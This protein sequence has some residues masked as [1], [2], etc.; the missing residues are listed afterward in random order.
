MPSPTFH[1]LSASKQKQIV[2][3]A[4]IEFSLLPYDKVS[5]FQIA[6]KSEVSRGTFYEYFENKLDIY[7]Y[8]LE[9]FFAGFL[10]S[11]NL[12]EDRLNIF[13]VAEALYDYIV[14]NQPQLERNFIR[15]ILK[16]TDSLTQKM[17][18]NNLKEKIHNKTVI[19]MIDDTE[20]HFDEYDTKMVVTM[21]LSTVAVVINSYFDEVNQVDIKQ[22]FKRSLAIIKYGVKHSS[23]D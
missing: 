16:N 6:K 3:T 15:M 18:E 13:D 5:I 7:H 17:I 12:Q 4:L 23:V 2:E 14:D 19:I 9:L 10:A 21:V 20:I 11:S 1:K 8:L 22:K